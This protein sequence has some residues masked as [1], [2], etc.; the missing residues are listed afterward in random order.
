MSRAY[1][2]KIG[3]DGLMVKQD[4]M[5]IAADPGI[6]DR[7]VIEKFLSILANNQYF[8]FLR[9]KICHEVMEEGVVQTKFWNGFLFIKKP[10][11][12]FFLRLSEIKHKVK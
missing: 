9:R 1:L 11:E 4:E 3:H 6:G 10:T 7:I 5:V 2:P 8:S 12:N